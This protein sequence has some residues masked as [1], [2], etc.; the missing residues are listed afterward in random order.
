MTMKVGNSPLHSAVARGHLDVCQYLTQNGADLNISKKVGE[1]GHFKKM[2]D[3]LT[4]SINPKAGDQTPLHLAV[5][6]GHLEICQW[7]IQNGANLE[8][9]DYVSQAFKNKGK[10]INL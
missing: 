7:L 2:D 8:V 6:D 1:L 3:E 4:L 5:K 10:K 9:R